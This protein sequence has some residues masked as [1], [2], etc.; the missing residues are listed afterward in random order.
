MMF[1]IGN[2][3]G[4]QRSALGTFFGA[5][6][7]NLNNQVSWS[8]RKSGRELDDATGTLTGIWGDSPTYVGTG[9]GTVDSCP[10]ATQVLLQWSTAAIVNGRFVRGRTFIPGLEVSALQ[11]GNLQAAFITNFEAAQATLIAAAVGFGIWHRPVS[12]SGGSQ[13]DV[14][15]GTT[16]DELAVLRRRRG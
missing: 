16:W 7:A 15:I 4:S 11:L 13:H 6:D 10:D 2:S 1:D 3:V 12:A 9:A 14:V 5:V 8:V